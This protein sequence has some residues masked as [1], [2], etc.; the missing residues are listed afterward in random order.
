MMDNAGG[1]GIAE[2]AQLVEQRFVPALSPIFDIIAVRPGKKL[3]TVSC[4][5]SSVGRATVL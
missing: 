2:V 1:L 4:L 5:S 3:R